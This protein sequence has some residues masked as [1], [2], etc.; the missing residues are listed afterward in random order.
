VADQDFELVPGRFLLARA[1]AMA[2]ESG[3]PARP[4]SSSAI[5]N[6]FRP[7]AFDA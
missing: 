3:S 4:H 6:R 5:E 7:P 2:L 1:D